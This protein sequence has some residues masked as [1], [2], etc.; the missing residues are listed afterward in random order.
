MG[1]GP[2]TVSPFS[3]PEL[4]PSGVWTTSGSSVNLY[5]QAD[6]EKGAGY[7]MW[8]RNPPQSLRL[9]S[10]GDERWV[11]TDVEGTP[12]LMRPGSSDSDRVADAIL[13][14]GG[15]NAT[16]WTRSTSGVHLWLQ[17]MQLLPCLLARPCLGRWLVAVY[18]LRIAWSVT[19]Q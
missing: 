16:V 19:G 4:D 11:M 17:A 12:Y 7:A 13:M 5:I 2:M 15:G 18:C 10:I 3:M 1:D 14:G 8:L 9:Q 6:M